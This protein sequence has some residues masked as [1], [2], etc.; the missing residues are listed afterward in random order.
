M[1]EKP[2][3]YLATPYTHADPKVCEARFRAV[4]AAAA[5][6]MRDGLKIFSPIS[7]SHPIAMAGELPIGWEFWREFDWAY[8][9]HCH[10]IIVLKLDGWETSTGVT[11]ELAFARELGLEILGMDPNSHEVSPDLGKRYLL[12]EPAPKT[13]TCNRHVDCDAADKKQRDKGR[14]GAEHCRDE[15]CPDC[16]GN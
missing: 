9:T 15:G 4:N 12:G 6:L 11:A 1:N 14:G 3:V 13:R 7:H 2:L 16:F 8:L 5:K 10:K